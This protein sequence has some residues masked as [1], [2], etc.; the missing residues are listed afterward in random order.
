MKKL[1]SFTVLGSVTLVACSSPERLPDTEDTAADT[2]RTDSVAIDSAVLDTK[3][4]TV[5]DSTV[6]EADGTVS[7]ATPDAVD[8]G[9]FDTGVVDTGVVDTGVVDTGVDAGPLACASGTTQAFGPTMVGCAAKVTFANRA[10]LCG[11]STKVCTARAWKGLR[12]GK[13]PTYNYWVAEALKYGGTGSSACSVSAT[14][15]T[16]CTAGQPMRV[17]VGTSDALG[18]TCTWERCGLETTTPQEYF[19]GCSGAADNT[20]GSLCCL[21]ACASGTV[22]EEFDNGVF[23]CAGK[24]T[25]DARASLCGAGHHVCSATEWVAGH[26][27]SVPKHHYWTSDALKYSGTGGTCAVSKTTGSDCGPSTPMRVC[28]GTGA[29]AVTDPEGNVCNWVGCGYE[30]NAPVHYFGGCAG[31]TTAGTL[32]CAN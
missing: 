30:T 16:D 21:P 1:L 14:T 18:N 28:A 5:G 25:F 15:G 22:A 10:T 23:G 31:N 6:S 29:A 32:C 20:A 8:S 2:A 17:C 19:G 12:R 13:A 3:T 4:D 26:G 7:D 24:V 27:A 11:G 9:A